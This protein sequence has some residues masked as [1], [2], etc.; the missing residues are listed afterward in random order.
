MTLDLVRVGVHA[1]LSTVEE[2]LHTFHLKKVRNGTTTPDTAAVQ[3]LVADLATKW[4]TWFTTAQGSFTP[5]SVFSPHLVYDE[6][7]A[8]V[9][10]YDTPTDNPTEGHATVVPTQVAAIAS[11]CAG[12]V[13][14]SSA[15]Q[16]PLE[17]A[18]CLTLG[19]TGRGRSKRGRI[20]FG[21]LTSFALVG[22]N[23]IGDG[24]FQT[25]YTNGLGASF[26]QYWVDMLHTATDYDF[27]IASTRAHEG[28]KTSNDWSAPSALGVSH[29]KVGAVPDSQ[30]RRRKAQIEAP[31]LAWGTA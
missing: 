16:L 28:N 12:T 25:A 3:A 5:A 27:V 18:L 29:V 21:G 4:K 23:G 14:A 20:Y 22:A 15:V 19:T 30:R 26:G 24:M 9:I 10:S 1:Q 13:S 2:V 6:V 31:Y 11:P 17:V 8:S 7:R